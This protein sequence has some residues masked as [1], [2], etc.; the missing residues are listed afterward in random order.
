M[1]NLLNNGPNRANCNAKLQQTIRACV[2]TIPTRTHSS[3]GFACCKVGQVK[4]THT[5]TRASANSWPR[6]R[7]KCAECV[8]WCFICGSIFLSSFPIGIQ[9]ADYGATVTNGG[10]IQ[11]Q[12]TTSLLPPNAPK[13][14]HRTQCCQCDG[15][16]AQFHCTRNTHTHNWRMCT[17]PKTLRPYCTRWGARA[18]QPQPFVSVEIA[19]MWCILGACWNTLETLARRSAEPWMA[20]AQRRWGE[21]RSTFCGSAQVYHR[22]CVNCRGEMKWNT[23][24]VVCVCVFVYVKCCNQMLSQLAAQWR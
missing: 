9:S 22:V 19:A 24:I 12:Q 16:M 21:C 17:C 23:R 15:A 3:N 14:K 4:C 6:F 20:M 11:D 1:N 5:R 18:R 13:Y 10:A 7:H 8:F 2:A